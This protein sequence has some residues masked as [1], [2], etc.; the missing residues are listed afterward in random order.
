MCSQKKLF[1]LKRK[2]KMQLLIIYEAIRK[3]KH[4]GGSMLDVHLHNCFVNS[5][6]PGTVQLIYTIE[7]GSLPLKNGLFKHKIKMFMRTFLMIPINR[8]GQSA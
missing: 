5:P 3:K 8:L 2:L 7:N 1:F 4:Q 6:G